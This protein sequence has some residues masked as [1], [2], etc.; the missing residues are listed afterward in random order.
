MNRQT[1]NCIQKVTFILGYKLDVNRCREKES[2][3]E[4]RK[5][6]MEEGS[7][8]H[9]GWQQCLDKRGDY[10]QSEDKVRDIVHEA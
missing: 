5:T 9:L 4:K 7:F 10:D 1:P 6:S 2:V 3:G 8:A